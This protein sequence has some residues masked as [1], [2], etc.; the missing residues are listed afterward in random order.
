M[1]GLISAYTSLV[2]NPNVR[3][4]LK[5]VV[6]DAQLETIDHVSSNQSIL[7][8]FSS[9]VE[10]NERTIVRLSII[11]FLNQVMYVVYANYETR[12]N[13]T[14]PINIWIWENHTRLSKFLAVSMV[15]ESSNLKSFGVIEPEW[16]DIPQALIKIP[17]VIKYAKKRIFSEMST[18]HLSEVRLLEEQ[19]VD[20]LN[21][22]TNKRTK[23]CA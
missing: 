11:G 8:A 13:L 20:Y 16:S 1:E 2:S 19:D 9:I 18:Q 7:N 10:H 22:Y 17:I 23:N 12:L 6:Q 3:N 14:D 4:L 15:L 5:N 21:L